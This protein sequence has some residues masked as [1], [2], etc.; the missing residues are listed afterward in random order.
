VLS[1]FMKNT[2]PSSP[3]SPSVLLEGPAA[4]ATAGMH[5]R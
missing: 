4:Q 5:S 2:A 1:G 3:Y